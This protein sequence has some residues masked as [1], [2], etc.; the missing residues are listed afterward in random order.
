MMETIK[1][2]IETFAIILAPI[3]AVWVGQKLHDNELRRNDKLAIFKT[4]MATR[5][6]WNLESVKS[7]NIIEI[8][9]SDNENVINCWKKYYDKLCIQNPNDTDYK[10]IKDAQESLLEAMANSLGYKDKV[11]LKTIQN[12]YIP[13]GMQQDTEMEKEFKLCQLA[14]IKQQIQLGKNTNKSNAL[15]PKQK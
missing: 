12:P 5:N 13:L 6:S 9:F 4:L 1:L 10:K 8:V 14:W 3:T 2:I 11:T 7:L 15:D